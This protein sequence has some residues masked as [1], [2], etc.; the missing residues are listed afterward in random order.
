VII[1]CEGA[2]ERVGLRTAEPA[3][4][5][6][7]RDLFMTVRGSQLVAGGLPSPIVAV[8]VDQ[9]YRVQGA[10]YSAQHPKAESLIIVREHAP[11][12]RLLLDRG[13]RNWHVV[14]LALM[15]SARNA[16]IGREIMQAIAAAARE[17]GAKLLSLAVATT[18][19]DA[20]RFYTRLGFVDLTSEATVS[21]LRMEMMLEG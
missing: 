13:A 4:E 12:G 7:L 15:P 21:H 3:D 16:G 6:F 5:P 9:Q 10:G 11:V 18:N 8:V 20:R 14:D 2:G 17:Q 1:R 19:A